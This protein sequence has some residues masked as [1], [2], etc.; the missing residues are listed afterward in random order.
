[1]V[2]APALEVVGLAF[3]IGEFSFHDLCLRIEEGEYFVLMGPN[4]SGK[5]ML[6]K[7]IAGLLRPSSGEIMIGGKRVTH[8]A[9]WERGIGYVP[10]IETLFPH[11]SVRD[12]IA[13][14]L[15]VR[16]VGRRDRSQQAAAAADRLGIAHLLDRRP[17]G[18]SG[19]E[20]Q[21]VSLA[22]ALVL[23][24]SVLLLDEPTSA[25]DEE[26]LDAV[27]G[28]LKLLQADLGTT[29][30]QVSHSWAECKLVA[31][32]V[33]VLRDGAVH[34]LTEEEWEERLAH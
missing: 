15:E 32:R 33:G 34:Y 2:E 24:P 1:M 25:V 11:M 31:D 7:L 28:D 5:T 23:E 17:V 21:K 19:G 16:G 6:I 8:L 14:G 27:C 29:T 4:G 12:N 9:P 18:L 26:A 13:F 20:Q 3:R 22:R 10:Q 30:L